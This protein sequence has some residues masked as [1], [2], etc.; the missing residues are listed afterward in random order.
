[1]SILVEVLNNF[2][3]QVHSGPPTQVLHIKHFPKLINIIKMKHLPTAELVG[4]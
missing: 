3:V 2:Q 4:A 1:M